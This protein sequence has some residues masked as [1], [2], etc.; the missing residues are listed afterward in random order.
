MNKRFAVCIKYSVSYGLLFMIFILY[1]ALLFVSAVSCSSEELKVDEVLFTVRGEPVT[2]AEYLHVM[3]GLKSE[4]YSY[5]SGKYGPSVNQAFWSESFNGEVPSLLLKAKTLST[6]KKIKTEQYLFKQYGI[7]DDISYPCFIRELDAENERRRITKANNQPVYGPL[8]FDE[9][10]YY[11]Y[12]NSER[13]HKLRN[14]LADSELKV[15]DNE[16]REFY[17]ENADYKTTP[18]EETRGQIRKQLT[19]M[20]YEKMIE[21]MANEAN[22]VMNTKAIEKVTLYYLK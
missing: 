21:R 14:I 11:D 8:Q 2:A 9:K 22:L 16:I 5:F 4:V 19:D 18:F 20:K 7:A 12:L 3:S 13:R 1:S 6:L 15:S 17:N 10:V